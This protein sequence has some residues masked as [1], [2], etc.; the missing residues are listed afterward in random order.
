MEVRIRRAS[1]A[2]SR[3]LTTSS[4]DKLDQVIPTLSQW[5]LAGD[6]SGRDM[7]GQI[8][9]DDTEDGGRAYFEIVIIDDPD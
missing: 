2:K 4:L 7:V 9:V 3:H 8:V 5:G 1:E 6:D